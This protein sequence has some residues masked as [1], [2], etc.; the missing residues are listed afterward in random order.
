MRGKMSI[1]AMLT[2]RFCSLGNLQGVRKVVFLFELFAIFIRYQS[3]R[4]MFT[5]FWDNSHD[6]SKL[7]NFKEIKAR[8]PGHPVNNLRRSEIFAGN[9]IFVGNA[10]TEINGKQWKEIKYQV[11]DAENSA[12]ISM[13]K[14]NS[15]LFL[16]WWL[17]LYEIRFAK[18]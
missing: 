11:E 7:P 18:I 15:P 16:V 3:I 17:V 12:K 10:K 9:E 8:F 4:V 5:R 1:N 13:K 2:C 14:Q 6:I